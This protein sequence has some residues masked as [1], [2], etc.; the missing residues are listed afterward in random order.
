MKIESN[1]KL[2]EINVKNGTCYYFKDMIKFEDCDLDNISIDEKSYKNILVYTFLYK[3]LIGAKRMRIRFIR[4]R[5]FIRGYSEA[6][7]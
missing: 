2:K 4:V 3:T 1:D 7:Y 5:G 6:R